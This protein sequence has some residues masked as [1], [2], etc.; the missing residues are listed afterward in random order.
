VN[1]YQETWLF[2]FVFSSKFSD[3][4]NRRCLSQDQTEEQQ[5]KLHSEAKEIYNTYCCPDSPTFIHFDQDI[6]SELADGKCMTAC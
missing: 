6:I 4:F 1:S 3:D 5:I 2:L